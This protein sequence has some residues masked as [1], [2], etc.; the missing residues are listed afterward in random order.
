M[1]SLSFKGL[2]SLKGHMH[3]WTYL[4]TFSFYPKLNKSTVSR[5]NKKIYQ[6]TIF[7]LT[8]M[9][10]GLICAASEEMENKQNNAKFL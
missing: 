2:K 8:A 1:K 4:F 10:I 3:H 6:M 5:K 9:G 7:K